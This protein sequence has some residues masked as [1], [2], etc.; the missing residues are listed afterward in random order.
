MV[1]GQTKLINQFNSFDINTFPHSIILL[2]DYGCGKHE[3]CKLIAEKFNFELKNIDSKINYDLIDTLN[4]LINP[5][6]CIFNGKD[7]T[8]KEEAIL[9]KFIEEPKANI[10]I[11]ILCESTA[12]M[13]DTILN[14]CQLF[15]FE[16]YS[17][18]D[19]K[20]FLNTDNEAVLSVATTP[21]T[22][23]L[24]Q[25]MPIQT[26]YEYCDKI[27]DKIN[28]ATL[29]NILSIVNKIKFDE[30]KKKEEAAID[31]YD[32]DLFFALLKKCIVDRVIKN[33]P[34]STTYYNITNKFLNN[35]SIPHINKKQLFEH[36]LYELRGDN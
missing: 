25:D 9:L 10:F 19:L 36:Y 15:T 22:V 4:S 12:F 8:Y 24:W 21:G 6:L 32:P 34:Y 30:P 11:I 7:I 28:N 3:F 26:I 1:I 2:G 13:L 23:K 27:F 18:N 29:A 20:Q 17:Q 35:L 16:P 31:K 14:R 33:M 5:T